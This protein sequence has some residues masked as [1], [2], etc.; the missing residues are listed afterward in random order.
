MSAISI[1]INILAIVGVLVII[2]YI[3]YYL[4]KY[5]QHKTKQE[6]MSKISPPDDYMQQTGIKCPDYWVNTSSDASTYTC[7]NVNNIPIVESSKKPTGFTCN[8]GGIVKFD[9]IANGKTWEH[10][11]PNGLKSLTNKER[12]DF[13]KGSVATGTVSRCDWIKYC[14][15]YNDDTSANPAVW[16]GVNDVCNNANSS[17]AL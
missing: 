1:A 8:S 16:L 15:V 4:W 11:N 7:Q 9:A 12:N 3:V 14:G 10:G 5:L 2:S 13:V 17:E 6:M